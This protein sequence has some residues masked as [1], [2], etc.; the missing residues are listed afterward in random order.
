MT[1]ADWPCRGP[2]WVVRDG[3]HRHLKLA[4]KQLGRTLCGPADVDQRKYHP[5]LIFHF[6][7]GWNQCRSLLGWIAVG[8]AH[9]THHMARPRDL[10]QVDLAV[11]KAPVGDH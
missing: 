7:E 10:P 5:R 2:Q 11:A 1:T 8:P 3:Q 9:Q 4:A 6:R